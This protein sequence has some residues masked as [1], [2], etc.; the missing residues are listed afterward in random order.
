MK[1]PPTVKT[2]GNTSVG[3]T[4]SCKDIVIGGGVVST[5]KHSGMIVFSDTTGDEDKIAKILNRKYDGLNASNDGS[6]LLFMKNGDSTGNKPDR[7]R[8]YGNQVVLQGGGSLTE[9]DPNNEVFEDGYEF[10]CDPALTVSDTNVVNVGLNTGTIDFKVKYNNSKFE[11]NGKKDVGLRLHKGVTYKFDQSDSSNSNHRLKFVNDTLNNTTDGI[12]Q[13]LSG[14]PGS[15]GAYTQ[16][17]FTSD[18]SSYTI[19]IFDSVNDSGTSYTSSNIDIS[20]N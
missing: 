9:T 10:M 7:I 8:I 20:K 14:T 4:V 12:N 1:I 19:K 6:E 16:V 5:D 17:T 11:I 3:G 2:M 15:S 18:A 13:T